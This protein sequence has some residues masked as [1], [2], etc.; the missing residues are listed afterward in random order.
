MWT[1]ACGTLLAGYTFWGAFTT[2]A[3]ARKYAKRVEGEC[4][5]VKIHMV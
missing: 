1:V 5:I 2:L 4:F 3:A